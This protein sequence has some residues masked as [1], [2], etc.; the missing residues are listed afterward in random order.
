M[1]A[2][3]LLLCFCWM[4][5]R[6]ILGITRA[7][8]P[9]L[10]R[11]SLM[12]SLP[13]ILSQRPLSCPPTVACSVSQCSLPCSLS[14][15]GCFP[16]PPW[17]WIWKV[18]C[19]RALSKFHRLRICRSYLWLLRSHVRSILPIL[20]QRMCLVSLNASHTN[21]SSRP[22]FCEGRGLSAH[23][24]GTMIRS[25]CWKFIIRM[26]QV[27]QLPVLVPGPCTLSKRNPCLVL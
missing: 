12:L 18:W 16:H 21:H 7:G 2:L 24:G 15:E 9:Y 14:K 3:S 6:I 23:L 19:A 20:F 17:L 4:M 26:V 10:L 27:N 25:P 8:G 1:L 11:S 13:L 22:C 5:G